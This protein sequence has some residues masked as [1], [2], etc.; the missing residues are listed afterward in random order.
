MLAGIGG[1]SSPGVARLLALMVTA[2][3]NF[4]QKL[5]PLVPVLFFIFAFTVAWVSSPL[6]KLPFSNP[7]QVVGPLSILAYNP[8]NNILR[9]IFLIS[10]P[11]LLLII[12][13]GFS[14]GRKIISPHHL[15][16]SEH[17]YP[18]FA[19]CYY[20]YIIGF[21][22]I[23]V[24]FLIAGDFNL[25][26]QYS[27]MEPLDTYH[28]GE[29]LGAAIDYLHHKLPYK[30]TIFAHGLF[31]DPLR[32]VLSFYLFGKSIAA[33]RTLSFI[34]YILLAINFLLLLYC[35]FEKNIHLTFIAFI[36]MVFLW[37][38]GPFDIGFDVDNRDI[39]LLLVLLITVILS[40]EIMGNISYKKMKVN[41]LLFL[42]TF[43]SGL[44]FSYSHDRG[45]YL[46]I[47]SLIYSITIYFL[48]LRRL[49]KKY[50]FPVLAGYLLAVITFGWGI[51]WCYYD[52]FQFV[53]MTQPNYWDLMDGFPYLFND[54]VSLLPIFLIAAM[55]WWLVY[56]FIAAASSQSASFARSIKLFINDYLLEIF[57]LIIAIFF[58]RSAL[59]RGDIPHIQQSCGLVYLLAIY[60]LLKHY[61]PY[62]L[63]KMKKPLFY[64]FA[65]EFTILLAFMGSY[66]PIITYDNWY[67]VPLEKSDLSLIPRNYL[68]TISFLKRNLKDD[69]SFYT[70]TSEG[71]WYYFL[72]K[73]CPNRFPIVWFAVPSFYQEEVVEDLKK[74]NVKYVLY[75]NGNWSNRIDDI[76]ITQK[77]PLI[78]DFLQQN[79]EFCIT[80]DD[81]EVWVKKAANLSAVRQHLLHPGKEKDTG[82]G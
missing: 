60:I 44:G 61:L 7:W 24:L 13:S 74:R 71:C 8:Y 77:V 16:G 75:R 48:Y 35:L 57:L 50:I 17:N 47:F 36:L 12:A 21:L 15:A 79:Y 82:T 32:A 10:V 70:M 38:V 30:E 3:D 40:L 46:T 43:I 18:R 33:V 45:F 42:L 1:R 66:L 41:I 19:S 20:Q 49:D 25:Y 52:F 28:E 64:L 2:K 14:L 26:Y 76:P 54:F 67:R 6:I 80:I 69:E 27:A 51:K 62:V 53:F 5:R 58:F 63:S 81:N 31:G 37:K 22:T 78:F 55:L 72:D 39:L 73:P 59:N 23:V 34:I 68:E 11:S 65:F 29:S 9:F 4:C 56:R